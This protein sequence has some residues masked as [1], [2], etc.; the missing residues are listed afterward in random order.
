[1]LT[2]KLRYPDVSLNLHQ[3]EEH[4]PIY[5]TQS[6]QKQI[7]DEEQVVEGPHQTA[8]EIPNDQPPE[9]KKERNFI[10][11]KKKDELKPEPHADEISETINDA[12]I[13]DASNST[14]VETP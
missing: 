9:D 4:E 10:D 1:M 12:T 6:I 2:T 11:I 13:N 3:A 8:E 5:S 14:K 7:S